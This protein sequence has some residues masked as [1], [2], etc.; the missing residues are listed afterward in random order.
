MCVH[1]EIMSAL[2][3]GSTEVTREHACTAHYCTLHFAHYILSVV[4]VILPEGCPG[5]HAW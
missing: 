3:W 2:I 1:S 4:R 5:F